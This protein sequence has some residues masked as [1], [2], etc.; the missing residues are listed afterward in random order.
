M[1]KK[2]KEQEELRYLLNVSRLQGV[3]INQKGFAK[4]IGIDPATVSSMLKGKLPITPQM[5][6]R[7]KDAITSAGVVIEGNGNAT[8]TG[9]NSMAQVISGDIGT[10]IAEFAEQ[11]KAYVDQLKVKDEQISKLTNMLTEII[12]AKKE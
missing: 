1:E 12:S 3:A 11:R 4:V 7:I 6:K 8:A 2:T 9:P 10:L 5:M